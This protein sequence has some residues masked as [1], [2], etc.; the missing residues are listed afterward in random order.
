MIIADT[1]LIF[2]LFNET[3]VTS[4]AQRVLEKDGTWIAP[5]LWREEYANILC[6]LAKKE[7]T[8]AKLVLR[9]FQATVMEVKS[10]EA[11]V[12]VEEALAFALKYQISVYDAHF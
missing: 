6:K 1:C 10:G 8:D 9:H 5:P 7:K 11:D 4:S 12:D 3:P 2:H